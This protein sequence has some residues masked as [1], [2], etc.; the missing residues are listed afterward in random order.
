MK[1]YLDIYD[2]ELMPIGK[3]L[4]SIVHEKGLWHRTVH[5]WLYD[6]EGNVYFQIRKD[7][8]KFY[9]TASGHVDA[10]ETLKEAFCREVKEEIGLDLGC[11]RAELIKIVVWKMDKEKSDGTKFKDRAF[12]HVNILKFSCDDINKFSFEPEEVSGIVKVNAKEALKL[13]KEGKGSIPATIIT[14]KNGRN[15]EEQKEVNISDFLVM[16]NETA[17]E[18]YSWIL[19]KIIKSTNK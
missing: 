3:E 8:D 9:T 2:D 5:C 6:D 7:S 12:A 13:F 4:R 1:D 15:E 14:T 19:E 17:D 16:K 18:K 11:Q 10:G